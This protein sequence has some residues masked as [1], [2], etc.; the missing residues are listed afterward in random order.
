MRSAVLAGAA[1]TLVLLAGCSRS[2]Q[3][4]RPAHSQGAAAMPDAAALPGASGP[5]TAAPH[6][7]PAPADTLSD[8]HPLPGPPAGPPQA[9]QPQLPTQ[10]TNSA[11]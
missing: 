1:A 3:S 9:Q 4:P 7:K 2:D 6:G 11:P 8:K 5:A 10:A